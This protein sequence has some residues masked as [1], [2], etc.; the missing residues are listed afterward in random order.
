MVIVCEESR[1][2]FT[3]NEEGSYGITGIYKVDRYGKFDW[4]QIH[5]A[6]RV[7]RRSFFNELTDFFIERS[8]Y[9]CHYSR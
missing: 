1:M 5:S 3:Q 7:R 9:S 8:N 4:P 6:L 2:V